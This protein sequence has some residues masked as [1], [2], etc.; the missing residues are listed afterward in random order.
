VRA[1]FS[2]PY[3]AK[4]TAWVDDIIDQVQLNWRSQIW[5]NQSISI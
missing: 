2:E 5:S 4:V 1:W 3:G